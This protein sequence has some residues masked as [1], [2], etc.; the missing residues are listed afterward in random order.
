MENAGRI[1]ASLTADLLVA[2]GD[3][4]EKVYR[5]AVLTLPHNAAEIS[6]TPLPTYGQ[7]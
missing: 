6:T 2:L 7:P 1:L 3:S 4:R 5:S